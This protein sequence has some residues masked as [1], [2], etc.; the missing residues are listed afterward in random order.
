MW[1]NVSPETCQ[2][3]DF[4]FVLLNVTRARRILWQTD[5][6]QLQLSMSEGAAC[7][8]A[9]PQS[10]LYLEMLNSSKMWGPSSEK[11]TC[12]HSRYLPLHRFYILLLN[13]TPTCHH[14][15]T[16][17]NN[18]EVSH[19]RKEFGNCHDMLVLKGGQLFVRETAGGPVRENTVLRENRVSCSWTGW[20]YC[21]LS[22]LSSQF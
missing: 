10:E 5:P 16:N 6:L 20:I 1:G 3:I 11:K 4:T 2:S 12:L 22:K 9:A 17:N 7:F 21:K 15:K 18:H 13:V 19:Q 8:Y 14:S